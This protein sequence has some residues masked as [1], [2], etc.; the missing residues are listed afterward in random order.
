MPLTNIIYLNA[1]MRIGCWQITESREEL[2]ENLIVDNELE[3]LIKSCNE[4][5]VKELFATRLLLKWLMQNPVEK[6]VYDENGKPSLKYG[7]EKISISHSKDRVVILI[8]KSVEVG[9]DIEYIGE[10]VL[11]IKEKFLTD[12][13]LEFVGENLVKG[14][15]YWCAKESL[16]KFYSEKGLDFRINLTLNDFEVQRRGCF[17]AKIVKEHFYKVMNINY[18]V[19]DNFVMTYCFDS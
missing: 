17:Q 11:R 13:E 6:I 3:E 8:S 14:T 18:C 19:F 2:S 5:R 12:W 1:E 9:I 15:I 4:R 10:K 16:Y 7:S